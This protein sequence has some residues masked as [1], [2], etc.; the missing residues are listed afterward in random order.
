M[1]AN[2]DAMFYVGEMPWHREGKKLE[3]PPDVKEAISAAGLDWQVEKTPLYSQDRSLIKGIYGMTRSD[4]NVVL[5]VVKDDYSPL[6]NTDAFA[7]FNPLI[8]DGSLQLETAGALGQGEIVWVLAQLTK[9]KAIEPKKDDIV[10]RYLLLSNS[11]DGSAAVNVKFT[12]I[13]VVCQN[14]LTMALNEGNALRIKHRGKM[15]KHLL[16]AQEMVQ[17]IIVT[18]AALGESYQGMVEYQLGAKNVEKYFAGLYPVADLSLIQT[19]EQHYRREANL[20]AQAALLC[21]FENG[22][23]VKALKIEGTLWAAYNAV[24]E[25]ID[26]PLDYKLGDDRLLKR[27]WYGEGARIKARAYHAAM[28]LLKAA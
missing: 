4:T 18:Y 28:E 12:P 22:T 26:H 7:F 1:P 14:T 27:I 3:N 5:G 20:R 15:G 16:A 8:K 17:Q 21:G 9:G 10:E 19:P 24:T 25:F 23:G 2:V 13:R 11:H 6:Q